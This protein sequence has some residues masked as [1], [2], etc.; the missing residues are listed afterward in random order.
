MNIAETEELT[1][2]KSDPLKPLE[3]GQY[4]KKDEPPTLTK[5][6]KPTSNVRKTNNIDKNGLDHSK[7]S[8]NT[9]I[10]DTIFGIQ[11]NLRKGI[12]FKNPITSGK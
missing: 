7:F 5:T 9:T 8:K 2:K 3:T 12:S 6:N 11:K 10:T 4:T 1:Q